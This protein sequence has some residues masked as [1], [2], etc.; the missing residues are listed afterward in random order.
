MSGNPETPKSQYHLPK[1]ENLD[2]VN[3]NFEIHTTFIAHLADEMVKHSERTNANITRLAEET[4][5]NLDVMMKKLEDLYHSQVS[6]LTL[7]F[8]A[9]VT[10]VLLM[11]G[12]LSWSIMFYHWMAS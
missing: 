2:D 11:R 3:R 5:A 9:F 1:V 6:V 7:A 12:V 8:I 10:I 4:N